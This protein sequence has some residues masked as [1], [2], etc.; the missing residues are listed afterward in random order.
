MPSSIRVSVTATVALICVLVGAALLPQWAS[1]DAPC[2]SSWPTH[3]YAGSLQENDYGRIGYE[4]FYTD[5]DDDR[6]F[7]IRSTDSNAYTVVRAYQANAGGD[8]YITGAPDE[9]CYLLVRWPGDA[10]DATEPRQI[11]FSSVAAGGRQSAKPGSASGAGPTP[12][13]PRPRS[14]SGPALGFYDMVSVDSSSLLWLRQG[15]LCGLREDGLVVCLGLQYNPLQGAEPHL[16][17]GRFASISV[18]QVFA[19]GVKTDGAAA[20]WPTLDF[21]HYFGPELPVPEGQFESV[22]VGGA[23]ACG[24]RP[25]ASVECWFAWGGTEWDDNDNVGQARPP[26]G[27]F[28][29]VSAGDRHT[30]GVR[31]DGTV[32]CW[33]QDES[34]GGFFFGSSSVGG[35]QASPPEGEFRSV[36]AG[37]YHS[38][39][40]RTDE[41]LECWGDTWNWPSGTFES[42]SAGFGHTCGLRTE[43]SVACW[44][45]HNDVS[46]PSTGLASPPGRSFTSI[47]TSLQQ[48]CAT[49]VGG[50]VVCWGVDSLGLNH[51][52][53]SY[54]GLTSGDSSLTCGSR[55]SRDGISDFCWDAEREIAAP[56]VT[57]V[58][59]GGNKR[60]IV[61]S[62]A[63]LLCDGYSA[64]P[65]LPLGNVR[66]VSIGG[67]R[68]TCAVRTDNSAICWDDEKVLAGVLPA[69]GFKSI[70]AGDEH[71]C[72]MLLD[73]S[74]VCWGEGFRGQLSHPDGKLASLS[75]G[76]A[77]TCG[78]RPSGQIVC[79]GS[80][81]YGQS[82]PPDGEFRL[83]SAGSEH[84]CGVATDDGAVC[85][86][87]NNGGQA[88]PP[89]GEF[90]HLSADDDYSCGVTAQ[91]SIV[92]WGSNPFGESWSGD[93]RQVAAG[94]ANLCGLHADGRLECR[95]YD[96]F[97]K[98]TQA[99]FLTAG[100]RYVCG[101]RSDGS[102]FCWSDATAGEVPLP[103]LTT[104]SIAGRTAC[105]VASDGAVI[106]W[107]G[108][109]LEESPAIPPSGTFQSV[110]VNSGTACGVRMDGGVA[111][112]GRGEIG[113]T[114]PPTGTFRSVSVGR[115]H[116]CGVL[117]DGAV[118]CWEDADHD[119]P[120]P[121]AGKFASI[122]S[123]DEHVCAVRD[124]GAVACW[125]TAQ[126]ELLPGPEGRFK[127]LDLDSRD[128]ACGVRIDG[129]IICWLAG[130][131][132]ELSTLGGPPGKFV[133]VSVED[134][135]ACGIREEGDAT[136][137]IFWSGCQRSSNG[138]ACT[139]DEDVNSVELTEGKFRE[140]FVVDTFNVCGLTLDGELRCGLR[141]EEL[142]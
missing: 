100:D 72:G 61:S 36:S 16:P 6:W 69:D 39:G 43:G 31:I 11:T 103:R 115:R 4:D 42:V 129:E 131:S 65:W 24:I 48:V 142:D 120:P 79:W 119:L 109:P 135:L 88:A 26:E 130:S 76:R 118:Q 123:G 102:Q 22:S 75:A 141:L 122:H 92:C 21:L 134:N 63:D 136:C 9:V 127:T 58:S 93:F 137:W 14:E 2:P 23:H 114:M 71:A 110:S 105:G 27:E 106:C 57:V 20:C 117:Q 34:E 94:E 116:V 74:V 80:D 1:A 19:C 59:V 51:R 54:A 113:K 67:F 60:C 46:S 10:V 44:G 55:L 45:A 66:S 83:V 37:S 140:I 50:S 52:T 91:G 8:G 47:A 125:E 64:Y 98:L 32:A 128:K 68:Q 107:A 49:E 28:R 138:S 40:I 95:G 101:G 86:G 62:E 29:S 90:R 13:E 25:D 56:K 133:S 77:H 126:S 12:S 84:T 97:A 17:T 33:G 38:C 41:T 5:A 35:G 111:C 18:G 7:V 82:S 121:P 15:P 85:W 81:E 89:A 70:S 87:N 139:P 104:A 78:L 132:G 99:S 112:W 73:D 3:G 30:C 53:S 108:D 124:D 96:Y